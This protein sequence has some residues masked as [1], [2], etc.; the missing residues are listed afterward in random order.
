MSVVASVFGRVGAVLAQ[1]GDYAA[2]LVANDSAVSG[3][4]VRDA[5]DALNAQSPTWPATTKALASGGPIPSL[6]GTLVN[7]GLFVAPPAGQW[8]IY[9]VE[10]RIVGRA[11]VSDVGSAVLAQGSIAFGPAPGTPD[12]RIVSG[13]IQDFAPAVPGWGVGVLTCTAAG[14]LLIG[15][16]NNDPVNAQTF[17]L[18][19]VASGPV[20]LP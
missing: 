17:A 9:Q 2:S 1:L 7:S 19:T 10:A 3:A 6:G 20:L 16:G 14:E 18:L 12:T 8:S 11:A 13:A 15:I 4:T 5:L